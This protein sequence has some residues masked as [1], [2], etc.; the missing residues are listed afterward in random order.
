MDILNSPH[1]ELHKLSHH[2]TD[3]LKGIAILS[4]LVNHFIN[5]NTD[6]TLDSLYLTGYA[7]GIIIIFF[8]LSGYG[9]YH[10]LNKLGRGGKN[11]KEFYLKRILR[12]YPLFIIALFAFSLINTGI[13]PSFSSFFFIQSPYWFIDAIVYCYLLTP[14]SILLLDKLTLN[15]FI[16]LFSLT[17]ITLAIGTY[18]TS[19][20]TLPISM[21]RYRYIFFSFFLG[22][23]GGMA[24]MKYHNELLKSPFLDFTGLYIGIFTI[25]LY[26]TRTPMDWAIQVIAGVIFIVA[27]LLLIGSIQKT[28][29]LQN[30]ELKIL[31]FLGAISYTIYLFQPIFYQ[32][33]YRFTNHDSILSLI[34]IL[35]FFPIF[36]MLCYF[37]EII[38]KKIKISLLHLQPQKINKKLG[39]N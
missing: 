17:L 5:D 31:A 15:R 19:E 11:W 21:L 33:V 27:S 23:I 13:L 22:Y 25:F 32:L 26:F 38:V 30:K 29:C 2:E 6:K 24:L 34:A 10:S 7:N 18:L 28:G 36:I 4:V 20:F 35:F 9:V 37:F 16:I 8:I 14:L 3:I 1:L 12:I 39:L